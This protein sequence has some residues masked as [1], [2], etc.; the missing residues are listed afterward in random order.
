MTWRI[1]R[2]GTTPPNHRLH[3]GFT[4][5]EVLIALFIVSVS[6]LG[7]AGL[8]LTGMRFTQESVYRTKAALL[9]MDMANRMYANQSAL[10]QYSGNTSVTFSQDCAVSNC[11]PSQMADYD[12]AQWNTVISSDLPNGAG[13]I[14]GTDPYTVAVIWYSRDDEE[15]KSE[16]LEFSP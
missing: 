1:H 5:I 3:G 14:S 4:F 13:G 16:S 11:T 12:V 9:T 2:P 15:F 7:I 6:L 8:Q 10:A